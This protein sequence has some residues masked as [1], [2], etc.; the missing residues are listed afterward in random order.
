MCRID[1]PACHFDLI[2]PYCFPEKEICE[3]DKDQ[4]DNKTDM[5]LGFVSNYGENPIDAEFGGLTQRR[6]G[7]CSGQNASHVK[8]EK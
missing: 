1:I 7:C 4:K 3:K 5:Q 6:A 2:S 8:R